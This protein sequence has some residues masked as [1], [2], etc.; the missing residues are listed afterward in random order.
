MILSDGDLSTLANMM[1]NL[2]FN[3]ISVETNMLETT[4]DPYMVSHLP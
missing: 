2:E 3:H 1:V 4:E